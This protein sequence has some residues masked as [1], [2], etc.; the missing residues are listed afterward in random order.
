[1]SPLEALEGALFVLVALGVVYSLYGAFLVRRFARKPPRSSEPRPGVTLLKPLCGAE[2]GLYENLRSFCE[3]GY[4]PLQLLCGASDPEDPALAVAARL[5]GELPGSDIEVTQDRRVHGLNLKIGNLL[6]MVGRA[7]HELLVITD[8][9]IRISPGYFEAL[10]AGLSD[11]GVG[12][13]TC[14]YVAHPEAGLWSDLGAM[15][16][17]HRFL[18]AVLIAES[19]GLKRGAFGATLAIRRKT[20][21]EIGG[22]EPLR[23]VLADDYLLAESVRKAGLRVVLSERLVDMVIAEPSAS[24]LLRHE[25]RWMRT[26][27]SLAPWGYAGM[28]ITHPVALAALALPVAG[29]SLF[30]WGML[31]LAA[32]ARFLNGVTVNRSLGLP[33]PRL[34]RLALREMLS[35]VLF[36]AGLVGSSVEWRGRRLRLEPDGSLAQLG[37]SRS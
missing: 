14:L 36:L 22:L 16:V 37:G 20:L 12:L 1:M 7:R 17:N 33:S 34:S 13:V 2:P 6:N 21:D 32:L 23:D 9:D 31:L 15:G 10:A 11:P 4:L 24:A 27:R 18:P 28:V 26:I 29:F 8:S 30:S 3:T 35:F 19:L 5:K 25:L